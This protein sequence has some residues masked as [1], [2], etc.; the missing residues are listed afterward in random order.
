MSE[1]QEDID[2]VSASDIGSYV[3]CARAFW[4]QKVQDEQVGQEARER[5]E[6]GTQKHHE[7]GVRYDR[8]RQVA[9]VGKWILLAAALI[10]ALWVVSHMGWLG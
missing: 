7:H 5:L 6:E 10:G 9:R 1:P 4:L 2:W 3:Y 8:Q